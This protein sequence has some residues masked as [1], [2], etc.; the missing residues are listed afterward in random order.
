MQIDDNLK[1]SDAGAVLCVHC[2][3]RVGDTAERPLQY[4]LRHDRPSSAA[5]A[6]VRADPARFTERPI[7]LRQIFCP[8]CLTLLE[9][10]IVPED[11]RSYRNWVL[12]V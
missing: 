12:A 9:S 8:G 2:A 3:A 10:E 7:V 11:E 4:A 5:G 1:I 6:G